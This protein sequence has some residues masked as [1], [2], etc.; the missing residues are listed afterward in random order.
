MSLDLQFRLHRCGWFLGVT[1]FS[2][3]ETR[4][5]LGRPV[6]MFGPGS[7]DTLRAVFPD[8][9][10]QRVTVVDVYLVPC[11]PLRLTLRRRAG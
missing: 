8:A 10:Y 9:A 5:P 4:D 1:W 7:L 6:L 3:H 11:L 2:G